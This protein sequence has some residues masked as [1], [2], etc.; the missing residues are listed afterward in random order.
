[1]KMIKAIIKNPEEE[2]GHMC[3]I[4]DDLEALQAI[5]GGYIETIPASEKDNV[6]IIMDEE[7]QLK[8]K[9]ENLALGTALIVGTIIV[10]GQK[11]ENLCNVP[12]DF[13]R[14]KRFVDMRRPLF[15]GIG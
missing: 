1:M 5:V 11:G 7:G 3:W 6:M 12:W 15:G 10:C 9:E 8:G 14:W 2:Y 4:S 13:D